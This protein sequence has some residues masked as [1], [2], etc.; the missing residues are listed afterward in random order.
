M[1]EPKPQIK[2][3]DVIRNFRK[4]NFLWGKDIVDQ[5]PGLAHNQ[6][7]AL[8]RGLQPKVKKRKYL[9]RLTEGSGGEAPSRWAIFWK[10]S[11]FNAIGSHF[12]RVQSH[13]KEPDF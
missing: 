13:L 7:F 2:C 6:N 1:G 3:N 10:K 5:K 4:K 12:T 11:Y 9:K 8:R